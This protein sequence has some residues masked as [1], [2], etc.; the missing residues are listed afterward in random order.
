MFRVFEKFYNAY[1][2]DIEY[3]CNRF[4]FVVSFSYHNED[5]KL[6]R[7][8]SSNLDNYYNYLYSKVDTN[9][10]IYDDEIIIGKTVDKN[11]IRKL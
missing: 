8:E 2:S 4:R 1:N 11:N 10:D 9:K 7:D 6:I 3:V 5:G